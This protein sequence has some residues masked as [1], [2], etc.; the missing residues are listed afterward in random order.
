MIVD[1]NG[2]ETNGGVAL[3]GTS[4]LFGMESCAVCDGGRRH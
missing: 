1:W 4:M 2:G 3:R